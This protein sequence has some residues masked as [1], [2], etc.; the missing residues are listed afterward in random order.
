MPV[1]TGVTDH[2]GCVCQSPPEQRDCGA[3]MGAAPL[4]R[5]VVAGQKQSLAIQHCLQPSIILGFHQ[6]PQYVGPSEEMHLQHSGAQD[7]PCPPHCHVHRAGLPITEAHATTHQHLGTRKTCF[8]DVAN[9][10]FSLLSELPLGC[11]H[12]ILGFEVIISNGDQG[13]YNSM[14][15]FLFFFL[16]R[17]GPIDLP[18]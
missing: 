4:C 17:I 15:I 7:R 5:C 12:R 11:I 2:E 14:A 16:L 6:C 10:F 9:S 1:V 3:A 18:N 8:V 13:H